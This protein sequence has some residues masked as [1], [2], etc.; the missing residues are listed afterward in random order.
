MTIAGAFSGSLGV[1]A[2]DT[3]QHRPIHRRD[4]RPTPDCVTVD[5]QRKLNYV[6]H[7]E[8]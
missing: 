2:V 5:A 3:S 6:H 7:I 8:P 1:E 4:N